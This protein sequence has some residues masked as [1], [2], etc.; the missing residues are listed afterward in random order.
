MTAPIVLMTDFGTRDR[1]AIRN[2]NAAQTWDVGLGV[3]VV[4]MR[5]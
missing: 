1:I 5:G 4:V 3:E 2:K